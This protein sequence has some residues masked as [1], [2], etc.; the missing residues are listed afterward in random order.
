MNILSTLVLLWGFLGATVAWA[1]D[2]KEAGPVSTEAVWKPGPS[3]VAD[4]K[5]QCAASGGGSFQ[6]CF[7]DGMAKAGASPQAVAFTRSHD[8]AY[9][10]DFRR[11]GPVDIAH[12]TNPFRANENDSVFLVNGK[13][14]TIDVDNQKLLTEADLTKNP[15]YAALAKKYPQ[16]SLWPGDRYGTNTPVVKDLPGGDRRFV[17]SYRLR[18]S[19]HACAVIGSAQFGFDFDQDGKFMGTKL[20]QVTASQ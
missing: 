17:A 13:P 11:V 6:D 14:A 3:S 10:R 5:K 12:V 20:L 8:G 4:I 16:I 7:I 19:C 18:N 1:A 15:T 2:T 9:L